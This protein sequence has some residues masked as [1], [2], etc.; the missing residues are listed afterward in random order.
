LILIIFQGLK[1]SFAEAG[2]KPEVRTLVSFQEDYGLEAAD[3]EEDADDDDDES[4]D[5]GED[6]EDESKKDDGKK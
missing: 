2:F 5:D 6:D 3:E 1:K 4:S